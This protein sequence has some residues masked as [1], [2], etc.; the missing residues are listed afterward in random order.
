MSI[1]QLSQTRY[2][3]LARIPTARR[4]DQGFEIM[5]ILEGQIEK[6]ER[7]AISKSKFVSKFFE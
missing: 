3:G 5:N 2:I 4:N 1:E 6:V 7:G